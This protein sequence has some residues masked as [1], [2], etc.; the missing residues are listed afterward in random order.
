MR[1]LIEILFDEDFDGEANQEIVDADTLKL[2][3]PDD[4]RDAR[5]ISVERNRHGYL[6]LTLAKSREDDIQS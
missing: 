4:I 2:V 3:N 5:I 1:I 6:V